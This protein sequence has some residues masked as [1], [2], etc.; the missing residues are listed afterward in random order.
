MRQNKRTAEAAAEVVSY[1][2]RLA[3]AVRA[4]RDGVQKLILQVLKNRAMNMIRAAFGD[5]DDLTRLTVLCVVV[6]AVDSYFS[7]RLAG[8]KSVTLDVVTGLILRIDTVY[9]SLAL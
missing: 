8:G 4:V 1:F 7:D 3:G 2:M 9:R 5:R 6:H